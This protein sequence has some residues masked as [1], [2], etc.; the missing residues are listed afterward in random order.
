MKRFLFILMTAVMLTG[1]T[2]TAFAMEYPSNLPSLPQT[3]QEIHVVL[4]QVGGNYVFYALEG[5]NFTYYLNNGTPSLWANGSLHFYWYKLTDGQWVS[6]G[7]TGNPSGGN[8]GGFE[9]IVY[10]NIDILDK[11]GNVVFPLPPD[12][13]AEEIMKLTGATMETETLPE[14]NQTMLVVVLCGVG[15]LALLISLPLLSKTLRI[16]HKQ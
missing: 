5:D 14:L 7:R 8:F 16:F 2:L 6:Q 13:L 3:E 4:E 10:S 1:T 11:D 15:C 12:P 9:K